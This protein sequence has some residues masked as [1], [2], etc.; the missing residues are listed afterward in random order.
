MSRAQGFVIPLDFNDWF[1]THG[2][3]T[4]WCTPPH[5]WWTNENIF[6][7][8]SSLGPTEAK[9]GDTVTIAVGIQGVLD[10]GGEFG[11]AANVQNVQAWVCYPSP[12]A[13]RSSVALVLPSMQ[14]SN[15]AFAGNQTLIPSSDATDYQ[16]TVDVPYFLFSLSPTWTPTV[17]DLVPPNTD[18]HCCIIATS[19]GLADVDDK[20]NGNPVGTFVPANSNLA[21]LI[22]ICDE[23]HQGQVNITIVPLGA[24][25]RAGGRLVQEFGFLAAGLSADRPTQV[26][27]EVTPVP[28]QNQVDPAV[29]R[30]LKGGPYRDLPPQPASS[31]LKGLR[32]SKNTYECKG[33]LGK[34]IREAEKILEEVIEAVDHPFRHSSRLRLHLPPNGV[35]PL[36]LQIELDAALPPGSVHAFDI[37]QTEASGK[38][39]GIRVGAVV[40]P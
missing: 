26:V 21:S 25:K 14:S 9:V 32:L 39:G 12:T 36:L 8:G 18:T 33:W 16:N 2:D 5:V 6:L 22:D 19:A 10:A 15:P 35:Q 1:I 30:A 17:A 28:Q 34:L 31:G 27:L 3:R 40:V 24:H 23:P 20:G 13:G 11:G 37:T 4:N 38:R 7:Q 29:L